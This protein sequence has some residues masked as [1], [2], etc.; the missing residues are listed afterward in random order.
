MKFAVIAQEGVVRDIR[1]SGGAPAYQHEREKFFHL[2]TPEDDKPK[3]AIHASVVGV[4]EGELTL[5]G[6]V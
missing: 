4:C 1:I 3:R 6:Y 5:C 2:I